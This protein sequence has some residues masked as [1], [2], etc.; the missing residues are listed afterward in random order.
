MTTKSY[1]HKHSMSHPVPRVFIIRHGE[2]EWSLN[3]RHTGTSDIPLTANGEKRIIATGKALVGDDRLIVRR[4]MAAV[5]ASPRTRARR[6]AGLLLTAGGVTDVIVPGFNDNDDGAGKMRAQIVDDVQEW[7]YG[8]YEGRTSS[9]IAAERQAN[10]LP[11]WDIWRDGCPGGESPKQITERLDRFIALIRQ[12]Y[13]KPALQ[14]VQEKK[15]GKPPQCDVLVVAHGHI[16]RAF[17]A[18]WVGKD[19]TDNPSLLL[20]AGGVGTLR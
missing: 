6:T 3:G 20:E 19:I 9:D 12:R 7:N 2:T 4:N 14:H 1:L 5:F 16:L 10:G 17:A 15:D 8:E 18:R 13:H 11:V